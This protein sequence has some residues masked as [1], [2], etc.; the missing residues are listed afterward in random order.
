MSK[1]PLT[2]TH[3][4]LSNLIN[5]AVASAVT[6]AVQEMKKP[7]PL[8]DQEESEIKAAQAYRLENAN[9]VKERLARKRREQAVCAHRHPRKDGG[10][11]HL[12]HVR[13]NDYPTSPGYLYCQSCE[14]RIRPEDPLWRKLDPGAKFDTNLYV[15]LFQETTPT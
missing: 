14:V 4:Q 10:A 5:T 8:T 3:E 12:V 13:D 6:T 15:E 7:A 11:S 2:L 1:E 9:A